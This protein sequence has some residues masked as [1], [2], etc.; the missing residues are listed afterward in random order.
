[1]LDWLV[2]G[3]GPL[4]TYLARALVAQGRVPHGKL[5]ILDPQAKPLARWHHCT[6]NTGMRYLRSPAP[7]HLD[8]DPMALSGFAFQHR[9]LKEPFLEPYRRPSLALFE[10]HAAEVLSQARIQ[11]QW[12]QGTAVGLERRAGH[13]AVACREGEVRARR[14]VLALGHDRLRW[15]AWAAQLRAQGGPVWHLFEP[16]FDRAALPPGKLAVV[17]GG[18]LSAA[19]AAVALAQ[20]FPGQV[21]WLARQA[22]Q[23]RVLDAEGGW[24][25][26]RLL[27]DFHREGSW[28]KRRSII[29]EARPVGSMT[30]EAWAEAEAYLA[31]GALRRL[32]TEVLGWNFLPNSG[33]AADDLLLPKP[34]QRSEADKPVA[35]ASSLAQGQGMPQARRVA[36]KLRGPL[37]GLEVDRIVL[38]T[39]FGPGRPAAWLDAVAQAE[40]LP[41]APCGFPVVD[42]SL[43][44]AP[45]LHLVGALGE[46]E[47]GPFARNL[48][49]AR[50]AAGRLLEVA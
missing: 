35:W 27:D 1:M 48:A 6:R 8:G 15:P 31:T 7:Y 20:R 41:L 10:A 34:G 25:T 3:G 19:Q 36:L 23:L 2:V 24:S 17:V 46:L 21:L 14:V 13:W 33:E 38:A 39:G 16:G 22:P 11:A 18:G 37:S 40:G 12:L 43:A 44:W 47:L 42:P 29:Q 28:A 49:G 26:P 5:R 9:E 30:P 32:D 4:G 45:G 50:L